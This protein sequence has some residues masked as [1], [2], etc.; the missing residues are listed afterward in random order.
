MVWSGACPRPIPSTGPHWVW[1]RPA[2]SDQDQADEL[3]QL[4]RAIY[5]SMQLAFQRGKLISD[6]H[7]QL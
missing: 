3:I 4:R 6:P 1:R 2:Q 7:T 5:Q